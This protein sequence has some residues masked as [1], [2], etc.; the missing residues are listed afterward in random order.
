L[1]SLAVFVS[2]S[3]QLLG[4]GL[5]LGQLI[6]RSGTVSPSI[7]SYALGLCSHFFRTSFGGDGLCVQ[8]MAFND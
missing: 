3:A 6:D 2:H 7:T 4:R 8:G 1:I 5:I